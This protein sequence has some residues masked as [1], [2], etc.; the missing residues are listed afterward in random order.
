MAEKHY[1]EVPSVLSETLHQEV[2]LLNI[3][4]NWFRKVHCPWRQ[5]IHDWATVTPK[6]V[7]EHLTLVNS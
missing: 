2:L 4:Y 6:I 7:F 3:P 5:V 1:A